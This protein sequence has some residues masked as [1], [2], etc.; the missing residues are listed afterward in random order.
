MQ[1]FHIEIHK[2]KH[3]NF[4]TQNQISYKAVTRHYKHTYM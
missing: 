3:S 4:S 2:H 1:S